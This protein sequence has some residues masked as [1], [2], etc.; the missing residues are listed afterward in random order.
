MGGREKGEWETK[1]AHR[2]NGLGDGKRKRKREDVKMN[3]SRK[4]GEDRCAGV[5]VC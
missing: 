4:R 3:G 1:R 5:S 2:R